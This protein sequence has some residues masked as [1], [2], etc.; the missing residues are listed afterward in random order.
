[1]VGTKFKRLFQKVSHSIMSFFY[2]KTRKPLLSIVYIFSTLPRRFLALNSWISQCH[3]SGFYSSTLNIE[4]LDQI[5]HSSRSVE[6]LI[7]H[8]CGQA[9]DEW[10]KLESNQHTLFL[11][12]NVFT[13]ES[14]SSRLEI[15]PS[16]PFFSF[17]PP[18]TSLSFFVYLCH[19]SNL[20]SF[21]P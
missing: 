14:F 17:L 7:F 6:F 3:L 1:M 12:G 19:H 5:W 13:Q 20:S 21:F 10:S 2:H 8:W 16:Q 11:A 18:P 9:S 15:T 4:S